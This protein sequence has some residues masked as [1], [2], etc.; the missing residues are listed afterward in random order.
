MRVELK[1]ADGPAEG[2]SFSFDDPD[3]FMFGR[4][5]D[6]HCS[7]PSDGTI[8]RNHFVI[9]LSPPHCLIIDLKSSNGTIVNGVRYGGVGDPPVAGMRQEEPTAVRLRDGDEI[10][11]GKTTFRVGVAE[12]AQDE[13]EGGPT[14]GS[15]PKAMADTVLTDVAAVGLACKP[16]DVAPIA[17]TVEDRPT[18]WADLEEAPK[19]PQIEGYEYLRVLGVGGQGAVYLA[20]DVAN[21]RRIAI[22]TLLP[23]VALMPD[24][25]ECF[26]REASVGASIRHANVAEVLDRGRVGHVFYFV[27][28]FVDGIDVEKLIGQRN[29]RVPLGETMNIAM[30]ALA[31]LAHAHEKGFVH[32]DLKPANILLGGEGPDWQVKITDFGL[33]KS[34]ERAG[35]SGLTMEGT[36]CGSLHFMARE[37]ILHYRWVKPCSDVYSLGATLYEML[38]GRPPFE[39]E[40]QLMLLQK[41]TFEAPESPSKIRRAIPRDAETICLKCLEKEPDRRYQTAAEFARDCRRLLAGEPIS[42]RPASALY[43]ARKKLV[44]HKVPVLASLAV[45]LIAALGGWVVYLR[46]SAGRAVQERDDPERL[47]RK[48][49][50]EVR[51]MVDPAL[52]SYP[53][54]RTVLE[55]F[56]ALFPDA[57]KEIAEARALLAQIDK[58]YASLAQGALEEASS[59]WQNSCSGTTASS[60]RP[61]VA[62]HERRAAAERLLQRPARLAACELAD[63]GR[64][65]EARAGIRAVGERYK[66]GP[67]LEKHGRTL[68]AKALE[69]VDGTLAGG[70]TSVAARLRKDAAR[71]APDTRASAI[72]ENLT[73]PRPPA[74]PS[75]PG[76]AGADPFAASHRPT[77]ET[78]EPSGRDRNGGAWSLKYTTKTSLTEGR[79]FLEIP[80][81]QKGA[82]VWVGEK[83][84]G[85]VVSFVNG[86]PAG[87][88]LR[89]RPTSREGSSATGSST[90]VRARSRATRRGASTTAGSRGRRGRR[91][92][93]AERFASMGKPVVYPL[94]E[95]QT[96]DSCTTVSRKERYL[97]GCDRP[98]STGRPSSSIRAG[99]DKDSRS[100]SPREGWKL[101]SAT[102]TNS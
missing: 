100:R 40:T 54:I 81:E 8:S 61:C 21:E 18:A 46:S 30:E 4:A 5:L 83:Q 41:I 82:H 97:C 63:K 58:D 59:L 57:P 87:N 43:L 37:Q 98:G 15:A 88:R 66:H 94:S 90:R 49:L 17:E 1:V 13:G 51:K 74:E 64:G 56:P 79:S 92:A 93:S 102:A 33:A 11:A 38:T 73:R 70:K 50:E 52:S 19:P 28:E 20:R 9:Q 36:I 62:E 35:L 86:N 12:G 75:S 80:P 95:K 67:W 89:P 91:A 25:I 42:A 78:G 76:E 48:R 6:A 22:K 14:I 45:A 16:V 34:F 39:A 26:E 84:G 47:A 68:I 2:R 71:S 53:K 72:K 27:M 85:R 60:D 29:G 7:I 96:E 101:P 55:A 10:V 69:S 3:I 31:G 23:E 99:Q 32:R 44:R 65:D 77:F 24:M